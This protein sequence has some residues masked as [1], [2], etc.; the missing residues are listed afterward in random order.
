MT[1]VAYVRPTS[2]ERACWLQVKADK[3]N[4][5][6]CLAFVDYEKAFDS[7]EFITLFDALE[8]QGV[9]VAYTTLLRDIHI[10]A[11]STMK[12][13]TDCEQITLQRGWENATTCH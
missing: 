12:P 2:T 3:Y 1:D 9:E 6:H 5:A 13:H 7:I 4:T 11:T 10:G 8:N